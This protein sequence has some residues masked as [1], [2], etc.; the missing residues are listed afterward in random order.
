MGYVLATYGLVA[1][2][3]AGYGLYLMRERRNLRRSL[4]E[5]PRQ[6]RG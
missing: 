6:D 2:S 5:D 3:L 4:R 1:L